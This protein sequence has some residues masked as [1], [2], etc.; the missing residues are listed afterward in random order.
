MTLGATEQKVLPLQRSPYNPTLVHLHGRI[1]H[2]PFDTFSSNQHAIRAALLVDIL[3]TLDSLDVAI[4]RVP[5]LSNSFSIL[6]RVGRP[7]LQILTLTM[8]GKY[9]M[10]QVS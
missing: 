2:L 7:T 1:Q 4:S 3:A 5:N 8:T 9:Q 10:F 6:H